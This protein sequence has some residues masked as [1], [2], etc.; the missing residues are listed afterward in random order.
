MLD[1]SS[2]HSFNRYSNSSL[3]S[4]H[5]SDPFKSTPG[6]KYSVK[7]S[8][9]NGPL[10]VRVMHNLRRKY[11]IFTIIFVFMTLIYIVSNSMFAFQSTPKKLLD[12]SKETMSIIA[13]EKIC[14]IEESRKWVFW[15]AKDR[16]GKIIPNR[17]SKIKQNLCLIENFVSK[18]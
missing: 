10:K 14:M 15:E 5:R 9:L 16:F 6:I 18:F 17:L 1:I 8:S 4:K 12:Q 7:N 3:R 2:E 13:M 11:S